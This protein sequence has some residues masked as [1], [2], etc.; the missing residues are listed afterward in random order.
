V[1]YWLMSKQH[2]LDTSD[3]GDQESLEMRAEAG[4]ARMMEG[5]RQPAVLRSPSTA[6]PWLDKEAVRRGRQV[7]LG[8][9]AALTLA[10]AMEGVIIGLAIQN[11]YKS[12]VFSRKSHTKQ[13]AQKRYLDT[14][15][16]L[17][18]WYMADA[19]DTESIG[20]SMLRRVNA[21]HRFIANKVRPLGLLE[22]EV[23]Q[24]WK[25]EKEDTMAALSKQDKVFL[26]S[27]GELKFRATGF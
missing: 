5:R 13:L 15:A 16:L 21:M 11:V 23:K 20:S 10:G 17:H 12:L 14:A 4:F 24:V 19:W 18:S 2:L 3:M 25:D 8:S 27:V 6:P 9:S 22:D 1:V 26:E 7:Y